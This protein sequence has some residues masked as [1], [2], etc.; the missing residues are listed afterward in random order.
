MKKK[1]HRKR[2]QRRA[3]MKILAHHLV[4]NEKIETTHQR[5][6]VLKSLIERL[7]SKAKKQ[8][9]SSLRY[10]LERLPKKSAYKVFYE[11]APRYK[12]R[13]G[14][15]VRVLKLPFLRKKDSAQKSIIEFV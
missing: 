8:D 15:Y 14:G 10:L 7:I 1:F 6:K 11:L 5:A 13:T 2:D 9:L 4:M 3:L 12:E